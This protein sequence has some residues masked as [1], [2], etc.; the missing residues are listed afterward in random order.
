M[1]FHN[2][3][4]N[5]REK[6]Q[7]FLWTRIIEA[8]QTFWRNNSSFYTLNR[9]ESVSIDR[10]ALTRLTLIITVSWKRQKTMQRQ[11]KPSLSVLVNSTDISATN[12][13][14]IPHRAV[15]LAPNKVMYPGYLRPALVRHCALTLIHVLWWDPLWRHCSS[16]CAM[17]VF[18]LWAVCMGQKQYK[19]RCLWRM[20]HSTRGPW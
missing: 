9:N 12:W 18:P 16:S 5:R 7:P 10:Q 8:S 20:A 3:Y 19:L 17:L 14:S 1:F 15:H 4:A 13:Q 11:P 6:F 2:G